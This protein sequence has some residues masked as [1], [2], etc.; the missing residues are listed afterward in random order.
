MG[1]QPPADRIRP[2][3]GNMPEQKSR[4]AAKNVYSGLDQTEFEKIL[5][6]LG[7]T[8]WWSRAVECPCRL[9][10]SENWKPSCPRCGGDG[11]W[12]VN[13]NASAERHLPNR[14]YSE[15]KCAFSAF[16]NVF[17]WSYTEAFG[18]L[19]KG[20]GQL[21]VG[22]GLLVGYRDRFIGM[23]QIVARTERMVRLEGRY[24]PIGRTGRTREVQLG[25]MRYEPVY[26]QFVADDNR[27]YYEGH[28]YDIVE[29]RETEPRRLR[30]R[31]DKGPSVGSVYVV[32]YACR[33]VWVVEDAPH[34]IMAMGAPEA[35]LTGKA[36]PRSLSTTFRITLDFLTQARGSR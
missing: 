23:D 25:T 19:P 22:P 12:Y 16:G 4:K 21:T 2:S 31:V 13:P 29:A 30:W 18:E 7:T 10:E 34:G 32:H 9:Q 35:G 36:G 3:G 27:L 28:D 20:A 11:W 24:V 26:V 14:D 15:T 1:S 17:N 8:F 33:P 5:A 6:E